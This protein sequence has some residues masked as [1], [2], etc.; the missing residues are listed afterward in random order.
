M[1]L[2][3]LLRSVGRV[4]RRLFLGSLL[5]LLAWLWVV[6][7]GLSAVWFFVGPFVLANAP[8]WLRWAVLGGL[9]GAATLAAVA[10]AL[11]RRPNPVSAA[12]ALDERFGLRER[13]T[14]SLTLGPDEAGSPAGKA[15]LA[16]VGHRLANVRIPDRFP[17]QLPWKP[18]AL[19]PGC[20]AA[21]VMLALFWSPLATPGDDTDASDPATSATDRA[22]VDQQMKKLATA[23][24]AVKKEEEKARSEDLARIEAEIDRFTRK[25]REKREDVRD[26]IKDA[27]SIEAEL[28]R[29]QKQQ[30]E[31]A[32]ALRQAMKQA[33][34]LARKKRKSQEGPGKNAADALARG[35]MSKAKD[36]LERLSRQLEKE[37]QKERLRRKRRDPKLSDQEKEELD[38]ELDRLEKDSKMS[39]KDKED[40]Q[41]QLEDLKDQLERLSRKKEE[42]QKELKE[43]AERGEIDK[44]ELERELEELDKNS[45]GLTEEE[46][47][48]LE[49]AAKELGECEQCMKE[50]KNGEAARKMAKAAARMGKCC[51]KEGENAERGR[52]LARMRAVRKALSRSLSN[53]PTP[54]SGRRPMGK[55]KGDTGHVEHDGTGETDPKGKFNVVGQGPPGGRKFEGPRKPSDLK[56]EIKQAEQEAAA[57][58]DRQ[59]LPPSARKMARGYF[60]KVRG[61]DKDGKKR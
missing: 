43:M 39:D 2:T 52:M 13:V 47:K 5:G 26:R 61:Q 33:E 20:A 31:R 21:V 15:L 53:R 51:D 56:D 59:R 12:L 50:G 24:P 44:E 9:T 32:D 41:K 45:E 46:Q 60:E 19:V 10:L 16:D 4:R 18:A 1:D 7:L 22:S 57:A 54:G 36:E 58:I 49:E 28:Q 30:A 6:A 27:T 29:Q 40:L 25:P 55:E 48:E 42:R 34:R 11:A 8:D 38:R 3:M 14:T 35:D 23:K 17:V 37:E